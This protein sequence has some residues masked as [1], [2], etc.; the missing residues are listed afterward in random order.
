MLRKPRDATILFDFG[1]NRRE[2]E[3][4]AVFETENDVPAIRKLRRQLLQDFVQ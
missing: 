3:Y 1:V 2:C 4:G